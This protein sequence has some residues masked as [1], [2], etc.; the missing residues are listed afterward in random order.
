MCVLPTLTP[1]QG[2]GVRSGVVVCIADLNPTPRGRDK[3]WCG[4]VSPSLLGG[5]VTNDDSQ[6]LGEVNYSYNS[7]EEVTII[8]TL[9]F[10]YFILCITCNATLPATLYANQ[11]K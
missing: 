9:R 6:F 4:C 8:E 1:P 11:A 10:A 2:A 5:R 7:C 3:V